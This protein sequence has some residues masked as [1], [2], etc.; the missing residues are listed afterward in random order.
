[1]KRFAQILSTAAALTT[2]CLAAP[3]QKQEI[4][5]DAKWVLHLDV[6]K[7]RSTP[8]GE[9]LIREFLDRMLAKQKAALKN[10]A[11]FDLDLT[12][13][14]SV[15]A[16]GDF[17]ESNGVI[18]LKSDL[19]MEKLAD[20]LLV[21]MGKTRNL[22]SWP[23]NKTLNGDILT[24]TFPD[25]VSLWIRPDKI[26][27]FSKSPDAVAKANEVIA[28]RAPNLNSS[29]TFSEFPDVKKAFFFLAAAEGFNTSPQLNAEV[30]NGGTNNPKAK[31]L[32][33]TESGQIVLGQDT[34][35][36]FLNLS[37]KAK[38]SQVVTQMQH[39][40]QGI[41]ALASLAQSENEEVQQ[42]TD[43]AKVSTSGNIV[44]VNLSFPTD[45]ALLLFNKQLERLDR[46]RDLRDATNAPPA[47]NEK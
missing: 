39:V 26:A 13:A 45:K 3:L 4:S 17:T 5:A 23:V 7:L 14:M 42:L 46:V 27:I 2:T 10:E 38:T 32:K 33:L 20:G 30:E 1:M 15:T 28:G 21:Q 9:S 44:S 22:P 24:Y 16:Y 18:L 29:Q 12:K 37:L 31:I 40:V 34:E 41:I 11:N 8:E 25:H 6:D 19:D 47:T 36:I 35:Q 43:S